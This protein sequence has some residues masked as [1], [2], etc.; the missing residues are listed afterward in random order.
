MFAFLDLHVQ[1]SLLAV[2]NHRLCAQAARFGQACC[3]KGMI[4]SSLSVKMAAFLKNLG[5]RHGSAH[6]TSPSHCAIDLWSIQ[7]YADGLFSQILGPLL[8]SMT[9]PLAA[10]WAS[11]LPNVS[12]KPL[13]TTTTF[14]HHFVPL[15]QPCSSSM[16][17]QAARLLCLLEHM[18]AWPSRCHTLSC[19]LWLCTAKAAAFRTDMNGSKPLHPVSIVTAW[20]MLPSKCC[21]CAECRA[22]DAA[23]RVWNGA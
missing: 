17:M 21:R 12:A 13:L 6:D 11:C 15:A 19:Y 8:L 20:C 9:Q 14:D 3:S 1:N 10:Q 18:G 2:V 7:S 22:E 5:R 4:P 16:A 23:C